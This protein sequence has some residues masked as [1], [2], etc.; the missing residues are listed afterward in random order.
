MTELYRRGTAS[1]R[2]W[3]DC[4]VLFATYKKVSYRDS[5]PS[6][7]LRS[8]ERKRELRELVESSKA[9]LDEIRSQ[10]QA[11]EEAAI[12]AK[13]DL[14]RTQKELDRTLPF[15]KEVKEKIL[16]IGKLRH[17]GVILNDHLTKALRFIKQKNPDDMVDRLDM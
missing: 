2:Q 10:Q 3:M 11:A 9:Q 12:T 14:E 13:A 17:E 15:E 16:Q 1:P 6:T 7:L 4:N 8:T 5:L